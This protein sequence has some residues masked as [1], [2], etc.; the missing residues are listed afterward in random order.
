MKK[1]SHLSHLENF[2]AWDEHWLNS[3]PTHYDSLSLEEKAWLGNFNVTLLSIEE[4]YSKILYSKYAELA[5]RVADP[6]DWLKEFNLECVITFYLREDD[7]E[8]EDVDD[9]I[10]TEVHE[11]STGHHEG[12]SRGFGFTQENYADRECFAGESHCYLYHCLYDN[13]HLDWRDLFRIGS[14]YV[15]IKSDEQS[16]MLPAMRKVT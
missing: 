1:L 14:F 9:N 11:W 7:P 16:G 6:A 2:R 8:Y 10:L 12:R 13:C 5:A 4:M 3:T 15:E